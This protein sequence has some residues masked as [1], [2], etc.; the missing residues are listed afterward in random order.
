MMENKNAVWGIV[1]IALVAGFFGG[2][3]YGKVSGVK[4]SEH[5]VS[6]LK[7]SLDVF[8]PPLPDI[9]SVIGG[10]ITAVNGDSFTVEI[11]S[12]TDRYPKPGEP[13]AM[14][15]KTIRITSETVL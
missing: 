9:V 5:T 1:V 4:E 7:Q 11:P 13:Q 2:W 12:L 10:K 8:V 15:T 6:D 14:E 3:Y